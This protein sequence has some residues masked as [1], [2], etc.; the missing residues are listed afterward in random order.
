MY[1]A[2][3]ILGAS[4]FPRNE[5]FSEVSINEKNFKILAISCDWWHFFR[6]KNVSCIMLSLESK[7]TVSVF[8]RICHAAS[9]NLLDHCRA[10]CYQLF[11]WDSISGFYGTKVGWWGLEHTLRDES[12]EEGMWWLEFVFTCVT[13]KSIET[14]GVHQR[15]SISVRLKLRLS[16]SLSWLT[17]RS[18][19]SIE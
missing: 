6:S 9:G 15:S 2:D 18:P 3:W 7:I 1:P 14:R 5:W 8:Y 19:V 13:S 11:S 10:D 4:P 17:V 12:S 16:V